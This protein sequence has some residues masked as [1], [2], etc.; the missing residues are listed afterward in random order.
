MEMKLQA[1]AMAVV[2]L[3][4]VADGVH[5]ICNMSDDGLMACKPC[6]TINKP[7]DKPTD[8]CCSALAKADLQCL[9]RYKNSGLLQYFEIDPNRAM[10]LPAKCNLTPPTQC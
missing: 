8:A 7:V 4:L 9:C 6:I 5:G 3:L 2:A 10:Q 1:L